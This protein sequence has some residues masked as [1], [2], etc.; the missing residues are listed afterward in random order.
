MVKE[1]KKE[2]KEIKDNKT[3]KNNFKSLA[4]KSVIEELEKRL[5]KESKVEEEVEEAEAEIDE[6]EFSRFMSQADFGEINEIAPNAQKS[7]SSGEALERGVR[8]VR[9]G[10]EEEEKKEDM[11]YT[12]PGRADYVSRD[13]RKNVNYR[14]IED[15]APE[16]VASSRKEFSAV[17]KTR[18]FHTAEA[19]M[20]GFDVGRIRSPFHR[21]N[22]GDLKTDDETGGAMK[23]ENYVSGS[24]LE[25]SRE[26][27]F[28][29]EKKKYQMR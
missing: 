26:S 20:R 29:A 25:R 16:H 5:R 24:E 2:S 14:T 15:S 18:S 4:K 3:N 1:I 12:A 10:E 21:G 11:K 23:R 27:H 22:A 6:E 17:E 13:E 19:E 8:F 7:L 28:E 9:F